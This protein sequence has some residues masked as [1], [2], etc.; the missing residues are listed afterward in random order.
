MNIWR[1]SANKFSFFLAGLF[2]AFVSLIILLF[3]KNIPPDKL[4]FL[5]V[6]TE[7][8]NKL[9]SL[10][11]LQDNLPVKPKDS[12]NSFINLALFALGFG[13]LEYLLANLSFPNSSPFSSQILFLL[14]I[15]FLSTLFLWQGLKKQRLKG[16]SGRTALF[17]LLA[18][19][20]HLCYN[21]VAYQ[22]NNL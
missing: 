3:F 4:L 12:K 10:K 14:T 5:S 2:S 17:F 8:V 21:L 22:I 18:F 19:F 7:E 1:K 13:I 15:H 9:I 16:F 6:L 20:V 11:F